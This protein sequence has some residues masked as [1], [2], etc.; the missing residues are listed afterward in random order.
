MDEALIENAE[1]DVDHHDR[2]EQ[3]EDETLLACLECLRSARE[4][5]ADGGRQRLPGRPLDVVH[6][7]TER[8]PGRQVEREGHRGELAA[9]VDAERSHIIEAEATDVSGMSLPVCERR[10]SSWSA[11]GS[12]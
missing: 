11:V 4:P 10:Y 9:V 2:E 8:N 3:E 1:D 6:C 12:R 7:G 5:G